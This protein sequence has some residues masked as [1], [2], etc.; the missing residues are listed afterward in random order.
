MLGASSQSP[1]PVCAPPAAAAAGASVSSVDSTASAAALAPL[2]RLPTHG[3][4]ALVGL[5]GQE[6]DQGAA[7]DGAVNAR[8]AVGVGGVAHPGPIVARLLSLLALVRAAPARRKAVAGPRAP[9]PGP[10]SSSRPPSVERAA[11]VWS[12]GHR[13][14]IGRQ[15]QPQPWQAMHAHA[16]VGSHL[17]SPLLLVYDRSE[18]TAIEQPVHRLVAVVI[19]VEQHL[20][21]LLFRAGG[22]LEHG[23][24]ELRRRDILRCPRPSAFR[25]HGWAADYLSCAVRPEIAKWQA[26]CVPNRC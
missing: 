19:A 6:A 15:A 11:R 25:A 21:C 23:L 22:G 1:L 4:A 7:I 26:A 14:A 2:L 3:A 10:P 17:L 18:S 9:W 20:F 5:A 13:G 16:S 8:G 24:H 12:P